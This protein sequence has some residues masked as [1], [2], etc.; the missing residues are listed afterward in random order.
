MGEPE[1]NLFRHKKTGNAFPP[2]KRCNSCFTATLQREKAGWNTFFLLA[3]TKFHSPSNFLNTFQKP[4]WSS[5][6]ITQWLNVF[7]IEE[8]NALRASRS[9]SKTIHLDTHSVLHLWLISFLAK[10][11]DVI[12]CGDLCINLENPG[13]EGWVN[14]VPIFKCSIL[15]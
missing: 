1:E 3:R 15:L 13:L 12:G 7:F 11:F 14:K 6:P 8:D 5:S 9:P 10:W 2:G 4:L